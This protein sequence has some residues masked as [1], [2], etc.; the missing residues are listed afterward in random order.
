MKQRYTEQ[1]IIDALK[2]TNG[3][4]SLAARQLG[5]ERQTIYNRA[6]NNKKI[7]G[8]IKNSREE[9]VDSAE[10]ALRAAVIG[11]EAWAIA[12]TLKTLGKSRG[13]VERQEISGKGGNSV[14]IEVE[15]ITAKIADTTTGAT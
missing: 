3:L 1:Q 7:R 9:L 8:C 2:A 13:Y 12:F 14:Q 4:I 15:Y 10:L 5:C 6:K 11:R